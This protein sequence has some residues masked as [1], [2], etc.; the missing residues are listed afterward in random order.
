MPENEDGL[1]QLADSI[2]HQGHIAEV[3]HAGNNSWTRGP[4]KGRSYWTED[5]DEYPSTHTWAATD[6]SES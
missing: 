1:R 2:R 3:P 5:D 6:Y 4:G